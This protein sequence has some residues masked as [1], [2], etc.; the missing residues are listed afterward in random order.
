MGTYKKIAG[1]YMIM[2]TLDKKVYIG[3]SENIRRRWDNH[4]HNLRRNLHNN[5]HLQNSWNKNKE[6]C[7]TFSFVEIL[8]LG[9]TKQ[10][11]EEVETK[12]ILHY[13]SI[14][15]N[16]GYNKCLPG[17]IAYTSKT[18]NE[19]KPRETIK[20]ICLNIVTKEKIMFNSYKEVSKVIGLNV[21][22]VGEYCDYWIK[23]NN[24]HRKSYKGFLFIRE[25]EFDITLDY[26]T[27]KNKR[28]EIVKKE[29]N[30]KKY[31]YYQKVLT[32]KPYTERNLIRKPIQV[33][34]IITGEILEFKCVSDSFTKFVRSKVYKCLNNEYGKYKHRDCYFKYLTY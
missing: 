18:K 1:I 13:N 10:Q 27:F 7:F 33:I 2:N 16:F 21:N 22:K 24:K 28:K 32:V 29:K 6:M 17:N 20:V 26:Y 12:W 11:Y 23:T 25:K 30:N 19:S 3:Y 9:L 14:D 15:K 4:K 31:N 5:Q 8:P 34:N